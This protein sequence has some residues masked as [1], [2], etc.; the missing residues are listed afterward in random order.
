MRSTCWVVK[1]VDTLCFKGVLDMKCALATL[2]VCMVLSGCQKTEKFIL[3]Q[4]RIEAEPTMLDFGITSPATFMPLPLTLRNTGEGDLTI[5][6]IDITGDT[7]V[8][9]V[10]LA[11][12][13]TI[14]PAASLAFQVEYAPLSV[15]NHVATLT[16]KS[17]ATNA[18]ELA[19]LLV[20]QSEAFNPC[21]SVTCDAPPGSCFESQGVCSNG[22]CHYAPKSDGT[23]CDDGNACTDGD[24]CAASLCQGI[25]KMCAK[26]CE[27][28][29][30]ACVDGCPSGF[31]VCGAQCCPYVTTPLVSFLASGSQHTCAVIG[32]PGIVKC[33]GSNRFMQLGEGP[34][35]AFASERV[36]HLSEGV[37]QISA[38]LE[39]NCALLQTGGVRC[40]GRN[41]SG[42]LGNPTV[43]GQTAVPVD[44]VGLSSGVRS[45]TS[46]LV[47]SCAL[48][49]SGGVKCW[50]G[51]RYGALGNGQ[52]QNSTTPVDVKGL[53][54][55]V[56]AVAAGGFGTCA[57]LTS[58]AVK[59][60]GE[61]AMGQVG[62]ASQ[63]HRFVPTDVTGLQSGALAIGAGGDTRCAVMAG[64]VLKCWGRNVSMTPPSAQ[65][66]PNPMP[67]FVNVQSV[68]VGNHFLCARSDSGGLKCVGDNSDGQIGSGDSGSNWI[69]N[70][71]D[72]QGLTLGVQH[73]TCGGSEASTEHACAS[74]SAGGVRCW[75]GNIRGQLGDGTLVKKYI[76][77]DVRG[78]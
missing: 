15:G 40:W 14:A 41:T 27:P 53:Q 21:A 37:R 1:C 50:G 22:V 10:A 78:L 77:V 17:D 36:T 72:V 35:R 34:D 52:T 6:S 46:G 49:E 43:I 75:G 4:P 30:G 55:G 24:A 64:G 68:D 29:T 26:A 2:L 70:A 3:L 76:P 57:L 54:E 67:G 25:Q 33:W 28:A 65:T 63:T 73:V 8:F 48:L 19:V 32:N 16:V 13:A 60:W 56:E 47:H 31:E 66:I 20:G 61:N 7:A 71:A 44:V 38:G 18:P 5:G 74:L 12:P 9:S 39:F 23:A 11:F 69:T 62:D 59:C 58:G 51:N 45:I 42:A